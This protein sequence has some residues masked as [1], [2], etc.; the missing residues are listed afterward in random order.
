MN[1]VNQNGT[2]PIME[3]DVTVSPEEALSALMD[4]EL[5]EF[6]LRRLLARISERPDL[7]A[8]WERYNLARAVFQPEPLAFDSLRTRDNV[9]LPDALSSRIMAAIANEPAVTAEPV[10]GETTRLARWQGSIVK[11]AVAASVAVAVFVG[12]QSL[13]EQS[14]GPELADARVQTVTDNAMQLAVD[15][16]AQRRLND[17]IR[18]VTIPGRAEPVS[19][20]YN[21]LLESP[22]LRPVSDRELIEEIDRSPADA[23]EPR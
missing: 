23:A 16:E 13:L 14:A 4:G 18:A 2:K 12:M 15:E 3:S 21:V 19:Q 11:L 20:S 6:E 10:T 1:Q 9:M 17:Y 22:M 5:E 8:T 7:L